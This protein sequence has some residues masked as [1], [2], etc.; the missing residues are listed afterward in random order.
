M[1]RWNED[2]AL[3]VCTMNI[4]PGARKGPRLVK[5]L[6]EQFNGRWVIEI[7]PAACIV[8]RVGCLDMTIRIRG[9]IAVFPLAGLTAKIVEG[10]DND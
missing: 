7:D 1:C 6:V 3:A 4:V 8:I 5:Y 10:P 9:S 2:I